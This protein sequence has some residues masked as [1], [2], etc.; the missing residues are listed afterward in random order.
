VVRER[1]RVDLARI[2][3]RSGR[4]DAVYGLPLADDRQVVLTLHRP[5][6]DVPGLRTK[7]DVLSYLA[8]TGHPVRNRSTARQRS[9]AMS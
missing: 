9:P 8:S 4:I 1:L 7:V 3:F 6:A 2:V 5:P